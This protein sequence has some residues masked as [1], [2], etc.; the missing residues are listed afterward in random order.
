MNFLMPLSK[1]LGSS[2]W[3]EEMCAGRAWEGDSFLYKIRDTVTIFSNTQA[4]HLLG[5]LSFS[6]YKT[7]NEYSAHPRSL[8]A[9]E[10]M[11]TESRNPGFS[12][13]SFILSSPWS[14]G[15]KP[16]DRRP[17]TLARQC[18]QL[19][20]KDWKEMASTETLSLTGRTCCCERP[21]Q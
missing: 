8:T 3:Q 13:F 20:T 17:F 12:C 16:Q 10:K 18:S 6:L 14:Q 19:L 5:W 4:T 9:R 1:I 15:S 21:L 7:R 2:D 11:H